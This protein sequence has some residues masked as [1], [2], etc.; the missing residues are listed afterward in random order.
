MLSMQD[1]RTIATGLDHPEGVTLGSD[2]MLYAGGE[3]GQV[4]TIDP[5][6][7]AVEQIADIPG[8]FMLGLAHDAEGSTY[9]CDAGNAA[10]WKIGKDGT[11]ERW[12]E[13]AGGGPFACPNWPAFAPDGSLI[14]SDSGTEDPA[15]ADGRVVRVPP[16]GGDA[17]VLE[18]RPLQFSNGLAV[19]GD[20]T[21]VV[22]ESFGHR[23]VALSESGV[24]EIATFGTSIPD[25]VAITADGGYIVSM[26]YPYEIYH[27]APGGGQP[28]LLLHDRHGIVFP[29]P[30]N[31]CFY[32]DDLTSLAIASLGGHSLSSVELTIA[33]APLQYPAA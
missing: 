7:G 16:G 12:C 30:T 20:G 23:L 1:V 5:V 25:G 14:V 3:A 22:L 2:G 26:Y 32:G 10:V 18:I 8:G 29:M 4:Y 6:S 13:S 9:I 24:E 31:V 15:L 27:V 19:H 11:A 17:E 33:G 28:E 21:I